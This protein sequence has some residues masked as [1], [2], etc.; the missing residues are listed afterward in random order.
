MHNIGKRNSFRKNVI[1]LYAIQGFQYVTPLLVLPVLTR[2]LGPSVFGILMF[3]QALAGGLGLIV[4]YGFNYS[5]V[6]A[7]G[8]STG[9]PVAVGRIY[10]ATILARLCLLLPAGTLLISLPRWLAPSMVDATM[11]GLALLSL[12]GIAISPAWYLIGLKRNDALAYASTVSQIAIAI[13][14]WMLVSGPESLHTAAALQFC[15]P[16]LTAV[17]T[18][19]LIRYTARPPAAT[20]RVRDVWWTLKSG[21][22]LFLATASA[23]L[24]SAFNPFL[25]GLV[26][27]N[28][29]VGYFSLAEKAARSARGV[30]NPMMTAIFPYAASSSLAEPKQKHLLRNAHQGLLFGGVALTLILIF[31]APWAVPILAGPN[32]TTAITV[33]QIL[34][35]GIAIVTAGNLLGVQNLIANGR[36]S[37]VSKIMIIAAPVSVGS[38]LFFGHKFGAIGAAIAYVGVE[39]V[40]T[41]LFLFA[42]L[43]TKNGTKNK[44]I[45]TRE[46]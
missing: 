21:A 46:Q 39:F 45:A 16:L 9:N 11:Q 14:I 23:G 44:S 27:T 15:L 37:V 7:I 19:L 24:Y 36:D 10:R 31:L 35:L 12:A 5:A 34:A 33:T 28:N 29:Q 17:I 38:L 26:S 41:I 32:F 2:S 43:M 6:R 22:P 13:L 18:H 3:W 42:V 8:Q 40:I 1:S 30:L 25:L 4:E 20:V